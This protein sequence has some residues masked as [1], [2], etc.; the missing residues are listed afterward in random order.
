KVAPSL[1]KLWRP[2]PLD[3]RTTM[4]GAVARIRGARAR[5]GLSLRQASEMTREIARSLADRRYFASPGS[6]SEYEATNTAPRHIHKLLTLSMIYAIRFRDLL[7]WF[8]FKHEDRHL[9]AI[10]PER[11]IQRRNSHAKKEHRDNR[12]TASPGFLETAID[13]CGEIAV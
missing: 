1:T 5:A 8:G 9:A 10:P 12:T 6:L 7:A 11:M 3:Q 13:R 4:N 2:A